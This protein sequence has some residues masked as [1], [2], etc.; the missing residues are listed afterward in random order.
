MS[1]SLLSI[2]TKTGSYIERLTFPNFQKNIS[3]YYLHREMPVK[4]Q[5][6][7]VSCNLLNIATNAGIYIERL[8]NFQENISKYYLHKEMSVK[9]QTKLKPV[10]LFAKHC[11]KRGKLY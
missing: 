7:N 6:E 1:C 5:N 10:L 4:P 9:P 3:K 8:T 11:Y 2:A